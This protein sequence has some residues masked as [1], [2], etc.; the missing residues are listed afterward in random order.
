MP[1]LALAQPDVWREQRGEI[2][3]AL[4]DAE[5]G[6]LV[7]T[8]AAHLTDN[9]LYPWV[10]VLSLHHEISLA[11]PA[12]VQP[13]LDRYGDQAAGRWLREV[14]L[15]EL[16][17]RQDWPQFRKVYTGSD[18]D[19][20]R[21]A[22]LA[23]R[24]A[25]GA[26]DDAWVRDAQALWLT[27]DSLPKTCDAP[28]KSLAE[29][30]VLNEGLRW[31]RIDLAANAGQAGLVRFLAADLSSADAALGKRYA[32]FLDNA[33]GDVSGWPRTARSRTI[34]VAALSRLAKRDPAAAATRLAS[35][36]PALGLDD[37]ERGRVLYEVALWSVAS[38]A[39]DSAA[40]LA[41]VPESAYDD[42]LQEWRAREA[43]S[44]GDDAAALAA[45]T[46]MPAAQRNDPHWQYFEARLRER[47]GQKEAARALY[48]Q[49]ATS[50][51]Y[52]GWLAADRLNQSY[53]LCALEP[54]KDDALR[55]QV[56]DNPA[57]IRSLELFA[58]DRMALAL[59]EWKAALASMSDDQRRIAVAL[60]QQESWYDRAVFA[61][62]S[63]PDDQRHYSLRFP[64]H[65]EQTIRH[66]AQLN[67]LDPAWI[68]AQ[69]R[70]ESAFMPRARS[71]ADAR[72]LMQLLPGTGALTARRLGRDWEGDGS[73]YDP[74]TNLTLGTAYLR[75]MLD[76]YNGFPYLAIA[77][78]N[79]GPAPVA[80]WQQ[81]RPGLDADFWV[82]TI[83]YKETRDYVARVLAFSVIYDWRLDGTAVPLSDRML[84]R[85]DPSR[86]RRT[87][88]C[89]TATV[90]AQ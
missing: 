48:A 75:Q 13:L 73:L 19:D 11:T 31:Q 27:A 55:R 72:G 38:Y 29:R 65:H 2:S 71:G 41:A 80:R 78:Y 53:A 83:P 54:S 76:H 7:A 86:P 18:S 23:A 85:R 77:A 90:A 66:Q 9:P 35:L 45:I 70:A 17:R 57:L 32:A 68:A 89:P 56:A 59:R 51:T 50:P 1:G 84:G 22:D 63:Q 82:E 60:A 8:D 39:P 5:H 33:S 69:T 26:D 16:L 21:C 10:A 74:E 34:A 42:R 61:M 36:A 25:T 49:A 46:K 52:Y 44:R 15:N 87:F 20:L 4:D 40:R 14:W 12:T 43:M 88:A 58:I 3:A 67:G 62:G 30:S 47:A 79:A 64:L 6:K 81:A 28:F 24:L 37:G